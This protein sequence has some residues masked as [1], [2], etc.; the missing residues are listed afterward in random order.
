MPGSQRLRRAARVALA[1]V[2]LALAVPVATPA[3]AQGAGFEPRAAFEKLKGL[4]GT[5]EGEAGHG[6]PG[7][8]ATVVYRVAS[9]GS[10]VEE[11]LF[12]GTPHEMI[13]MYHLADG[14]LVMTHYCSMANQPRMRLDAKA[15]TADRLVFAF[16]G[17]TSFDPAK[18][19]HVH[20][21]V[22]EWRG[23]ALHADWAVWQGGKE[24][25]HNV[26]ALRRKK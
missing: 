2:V 25:G 23:E 22:L 13:S 7:Q 10:V 19:A 16:D 21:G 17:G 11:T 8:A 15:S 3:A 9:G 5:W 4:A 1:A 14:A 6:Q 18:D 12:P 26:F 20:S 24:A